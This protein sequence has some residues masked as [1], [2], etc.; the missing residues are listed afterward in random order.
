MSK[1]KNSSS[2]RKDKGGAKVSFRAMIIA[3]IVALLGFLGFG[4]LELGNEDGADVDSGNKSGIVSEVDE[5]DV[6]EDIEIKVEDIEVESSK[7]ELYIIYIREDKIFIASEDS[8][9]GMKE[10]TLDEI[11]A[12]LGKL[13]K[14]VQVKLYD[15]GAVKKTYDE[16]ETIVNKFDLKN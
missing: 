3:M 7:T 6:S 2:K 16:V 13:D 11:E 4:G 15:E 8:A 9:D 12:E 1:E 14:S 10:V 5:V